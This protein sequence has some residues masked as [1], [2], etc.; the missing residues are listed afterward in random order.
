MQSIVADLVDPAN[1]FAHVSYILLISA[2]LMT[3]LRWLRVLA[4]GSGLAAMAHF[5]FRTQDNA[6]LVWETMFVIANGCQLAL[7]IYRSR[8]SQMRSE[9]RELLE[10]ILKIGEPSNQRRLLG[11][12]HWSDAAVG[13]Q[14]MVQGDRSPPLLYVASGAAAIEVD[15]KI[16]S[17]CGAGDFLGE[18]SHV[19]GE[20]ASATV[21]VSNTMR[22]ARFDRDALIEAS[23]AIPEIG[24]ALDRAF[25]QSL[26]VKVVRMNQ[27]SSAAQT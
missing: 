20:R 23:E 26:A 21:T 7:L 8:T 19:T 18:I 9:E 10:T 16:V 24:K 2:M 12:L 4:L 1:G 27:S 3:S 11:L 25:T 15:G 5:I 22:I 17:A 6:S 14:L 13:T